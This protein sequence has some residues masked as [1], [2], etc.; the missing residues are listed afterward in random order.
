MIVLVKIV[1]T[2]AT[3][4]YAA[5]LYYRHRNNPLHQ[6]LMGTGLVFTLSIA[7]VLIAGVHLFQATYGPAAWLVRMTGGMDSAG[8]VLIV[9]RG[10]ST[11]S[12]LLLLLQVVSG[13]RRMPL[14]GRIYPLVITLWLVSYVSGLVI[15]V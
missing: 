13:W 1:F 14:H 4:S 10:I 11:L 2:L 9:H 3:L 15:F 8:T 7:V 6:K 12:L 5:G